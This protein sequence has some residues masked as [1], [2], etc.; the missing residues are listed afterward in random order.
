LLRS[1]SWLWDA[2]LLDERNRWDART[3]SRL[4]RNWLPKNTEQ[5]PI[6]DP[7]E[8]GMLKLQAAARQRLETMMAL[9]RQPADT[10]H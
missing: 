5:M 6:T 2:A 8:L 1:Y 7:Q 3:E 10:N 4:P 9:T